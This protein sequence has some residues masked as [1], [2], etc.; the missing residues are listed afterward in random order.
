MFQIFNEAK[1]GINARI[2]RISTD[3]GRVVLDKTEIIKSEPR[4][5]PTDNNPLTLNEMYDTLVENLINAA[6]SLTYNL[7]AFG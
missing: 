4:N 6:L 3:L 7:A 2:S 1:K 5:V